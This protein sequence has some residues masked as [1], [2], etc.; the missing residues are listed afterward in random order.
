MTE[1]LGRLLPLGS[2]GE[3]VHGEGGVSGHVLLHLEEGRELGGDLLV[4]ES[5]AGLQEHQAL[6]PR[7]TGR[8]VDVELIVLVLVQKGPAGLEYRE[9]VVVPGKIEVSWTIR[10]PPQTKLVEKKQK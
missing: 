9:V 3:V 10:A 7:V 2:D 6:A 1:L 4:P 8:V 5:G